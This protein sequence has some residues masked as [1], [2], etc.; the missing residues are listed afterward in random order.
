MLA[1]G[2]VGFALLIATIRLSQCVECAN[3]EAK[4]EAFENVQIQMR[5][6]IHIKCTFWWSYTTE[7]ARCQ[8]QY[9]IRMQR[10]NLAQP[11]NLF[12]Q[13]HG[14]TV[15]KSSVSNFS[16]SFRFARSALL[17]VVWARE[18]ISHS[19]RVKSESI[20]WT[21]SLLFT[22]NAENIDHHIYIKECHNLTRNRNVGV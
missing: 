5:H 6:G 15:W 7:L 1:T 18:R 17:G 3:G 11:E 4:C 8:N 2:I 22:I 12:K 21:N 9:L 19:K 13:S 10:W 20:G 14:W 16:A